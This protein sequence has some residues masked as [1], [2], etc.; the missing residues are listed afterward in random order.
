VRFP[1]FLFV[2]LV[3]AF[4]LSFPAAA[5][6]VRIVRG[7]DGSPAAWLRAH[8]I[9]LT[10][11][12]PSASD[13]DLLPTLPTFA[14]A[15]IIALGDAT[16]GTHEFFAPRNRLVPLLVAHAGVRT[17]ALEAPYEEMRAVRDYVHGGNEDP[18]TL[19]ASGDYFFWDTEEMLEL[20]RWM[21]E[22]NAAV[23]APPG[24]VVDFAG[25]DSSHPHPIIDSLVAALQ[26]ADPALAQ[27]VARRYDCLS[28]YRDT[29]LQYQNQSSSSRE[30][31]RSA[32]L[33]VRPLLAA[34]GAS[35]ELLHAARVVEQGEETIY[36]NFA[37]RDE[38][39]AENLTWLAA[40]RDGNLVVIGHQEH[41]GRGTHHL[42]Q[43]PERKSTGAYLNET[44]GSAYVPVAT[45]TWSGTFN[46]FGA[47]AGL[48]L[49]YP[50]DPPHGDDYANDL[51]T[52]ALPLLFIPLRAAPPFLTAP[53][54]LRIGGSTVYTPTPAMSLTEELASRFDAVVW[55]ETTT[56][57]W[58]RSWPRRG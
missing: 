40:H 5:A 56:A 51:R 38:V 45:M 13:R 24:N 35:E 8:A 15:R 1:R 34:Q 26:P 27:D 7:D 14:N 55:V 31:C 50:F 22:W 16:H 30:Q 43:L 11:V 57:S 6:R 46:A 52:A 28:A 39:M 48:T 37:N 20:V 58:L 42:P 25:I 44:F 36:G 17:I 12:E 54:P 53:R 2:T 23:N 19:L 10:T 4:A 32:I 29:P 41:F 9:P 47:T 21:R 18:A 3:V 49:T 33:S